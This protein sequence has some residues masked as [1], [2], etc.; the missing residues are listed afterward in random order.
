[1]FRYYSTIFSILKIHANNSQGHCGTSDFYYHSIKAQPFIYQRVAPGPRP[2]I[3]DRAGNQ[4]TRRF[5]SSHSCRLANCFL[6]SRN[7]CSPQQFVGWN[8]VSRVSTHKWWKLVASFALS[9]QGLA[10]KGKLNTPIGLLTSRLLILQ[11]K[12]RNDSPPRV[13]TSKLNI[14]W[15]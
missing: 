4:N 2:Q 13:D 5:W 10:T 6:Q 14:T 11:H 1:M 3:C 9:C 7:L 12:L 15:M 8:L